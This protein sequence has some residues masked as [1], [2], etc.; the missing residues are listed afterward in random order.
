MKKRILI[1]EDNP[2]NQV[3]FKDLLTFHGFDVF[4]VANGKECLDS[5]DRVKPD[6]ILMDIQM[7]VMN[8][9]A[10]ILALKQLPMNQHIKIVA[11]TSFAMDGDKEK[12]LELGVN[13]Y[14]S[15]P[16]NTRKFPEIIKNLLKEGEKD[17]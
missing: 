1:A 16:I 13:L 4:T 15:K 14:L 5:I 3:L 2:A 9:T 10:A 8:G 6:L 17:E 12:F 7:P 11:L